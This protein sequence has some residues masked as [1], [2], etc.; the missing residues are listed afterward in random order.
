MKGNQ[1]IIDKLNELLAEELTASTNI[2]CMR[3]C[4]VIGVTTN[5]MSES[6]GDQ[7]RK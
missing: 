3:R 6:R 7:S 4:A 5:Y 1:E 2:F